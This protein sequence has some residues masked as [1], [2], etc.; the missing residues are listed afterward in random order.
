MYRMIFTL[1]FLM[2]ALA[3][4]AQQHRAW[5]LRECIDYALANNIT[6]KQQDVARRQG[7]VEL[8]TARNSWLPNLSAAA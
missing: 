5:T 8:S 3:V 4:S 7:E 6:V 2:A 1:S